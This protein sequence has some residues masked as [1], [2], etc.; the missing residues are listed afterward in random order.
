M[1]VRHAS[2]VIVGMHGW[3]AGWQPGWLD[4]WLDGWMIG[5][6]DGWRDGWMDECVHVCMCAYISLSIYP[7]TALSVCLNLSF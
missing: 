5:W 3:L 1:S 6:M 4:G 7:T 2:N